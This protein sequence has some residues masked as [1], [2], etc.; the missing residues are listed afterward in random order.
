MD[1]SK[2][3]VIALL[4]IVMSLNVKSQDIHFSQYEQIPLLL[5]PA[6]TGV[7]KGDLRAFM[8]YKEQWSSF[9]DG[10][11]ETFLGSVEMKVL[12]EG[13]K[14]GF[15]SEG[16][17]LAA[18]L[19]LYSDKTAYNALKNTKVSLSIA[20][21][22][23]LSARHSLTAGLQAGYSQKRYDESKLTWDKQYSNGQFDPT[24]GTGE[25]S[26]ENSN[27]VDVS[28]GMLW[29][30]RVAPAI[31]LNFG[32]A[33]FHLNK[34]KNSILI[35]QSTDLNQKIIVHAK[36]WIR[37]KKGTGFSIM[38]NVLFAKQGSQV[39]TSAGSYLRYQL[40]SK[41]SSAAINR[42]A[43]LVGLNVRLKDAA[44]VTVLYEY[45]DYQLGLSYD[46]NV[47]SDLKTV[48]KGLGGFELSLRFIGSELFGGKTARIGPML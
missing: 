11:Y 29:R 24:L 1:M 13:R 45:H 33:G 36:T 10:K 14:G 19:V 27:Y 22:K 18:G 26:V 37:F 28:A 34:P 40:K 17:F 46:V 38:P 44:V 2:H 9:Q 15:I 47:F 35:D 32:V 20:S 3:I 7:Y 5:N 42:E 43:I 8:N 16:D 41:S 25:N 30:Y 23:I 12:R 48:S 4:I 39:E 6:M 31:V 21:N